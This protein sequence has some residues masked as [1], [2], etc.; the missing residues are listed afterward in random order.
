MEGQQKC[1]NGCR[2]VLC[3]MHVQDKWVHVHMLTLSGTDS[4]P[5]RDR[6]RYLHVEHARF[7]QV[8]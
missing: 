6:R 5:T 2:R 7:V 4:E 3:E 8:C 1:C